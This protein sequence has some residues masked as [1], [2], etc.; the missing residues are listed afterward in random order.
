[1]S[2]RVTKPTEDPLWLKLTLGAV[3][4]AFVAVVLVLPLVLVFKEA[5]A[6]GVDAF[7]NAMTEP[8]TLASVKLSLL[9]AAIAAA[10]GINVSAVLGFLQV[11]YIYGLKPYDRRLVRPGPRPL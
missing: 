10:G 4:L 1:M 6:G 5:L 7:F 3:A 9:A 8:D 11:R 2:K